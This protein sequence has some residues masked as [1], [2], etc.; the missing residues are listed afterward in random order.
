MSLWRGLAGLMAGLTVP[1]SLDLTPA[2][3]RVISRAMNVVRMFFRDTR[4]NAA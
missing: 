1:A 3:R 4:M 2:T